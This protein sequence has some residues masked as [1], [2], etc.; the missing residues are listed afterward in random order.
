MESGSENQK[1]YDDPNVVS[2]MSARELE[3]IISHETVGLL[4]FGAC[5]NHGDHMPFG[6]DFIMPFELAKRVAARYGKKIVIFPPIPYGVSSHHKDFFM[7]VSFEP[8]TMMNVIRDILQSLVNNNIRRILIINGHDGNIAPIEL[9]SRIIKERNPRV[10]ISCLESWWTLVGSIDKEL[11][12]VWD[13]LGHG[14][15]AETSA[16]L[17]V[18]PDLVNMTV[19]PKDVIPKLPDNV[20]IYWKFNE[21][22]DTGATGAPRK[23]TRT[24]GDK[25]I[26]ILENI[27]LAFIIDME[28]NQWKYGIDSSSRT[29]SKDRLS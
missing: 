13:G 21:L 9:A 2:E 5:E 20:R 6:S 28:K 22:T 10:V 27:L 16:M 12:N 18:R 17:A 26:S 24:K 14:G 25:I 15:E 1:N 23:A 3:Q 7:T 29:D 11:F 19:A 8:D 4:I